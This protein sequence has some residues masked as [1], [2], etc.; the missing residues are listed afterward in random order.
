MVSELRNRGYLRQGL[1]D[2]SHAERNV[3]NDLELWIPKTRILGGHDYANFNQ[4]GVER[5]VLKAFGREP[6]RVFCDW[7]FIYYEVK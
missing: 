7:S 3:T 2:G 6:D 5:A 4:R 1:V